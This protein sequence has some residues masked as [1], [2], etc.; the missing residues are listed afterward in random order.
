MD[1]A[2]AIQGVPCVDADAVGQELPPT[3]PL[4]M[5]S[6]RAMGYTTAA[7]VADLV[8]NSLAAHARTVR[9]SFRPVPAKEWT[10]KRSSKRCASAA[11]ILVHSGLPT[12][13]VDSAS[14]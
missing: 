1:D 13:L 3:A 7:A 6:L 5:H 14:A 11:V 10:S 2:N 9:I 4:L 12:I 8:D